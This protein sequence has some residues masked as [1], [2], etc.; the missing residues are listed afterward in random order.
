MNKKLLWAIALFGISLFPVPSHAQCSDKQDQFCRNLQYILYAAQTDFRTFDE[1]QQ[2]N[3]FGLFSPSPKFP[4]FAREPR[5]ARP[6]SPD[7][8]L[9]AAKVP[10]RLSAWTS[11]VSMYMCEAR[12]PVVDADEWYDK[13]LAELQQLQYLWKFNVQ[14]PG[15][16]HYVDAGPADCDAPITDGLYITDGP[17]AGQCPLH[18][19][20]VRQPDGTDSIHFW[21][22]SYTS[23]F[24]A[25][26]QGA[27]PVGLNA[28]KAPVGSGSATTQVA[29]VSSGAATA[30]P[31]SSTSPAPAE[32]PAI[33]SGSAVASSG[34]SAPATDDH[35]P[36]AHPGCDEFCQSLKKVLEDRWTAFKELNGVAAGSGTADAS[37]SANVSAAS[38]VKLSG[39]SSCSIR[40]LPP[41]SERSAAN[42]PISRVRLTPATLKGKP[43]PTPTQYVC[44]WPE[45]SPAAAESQFETL[46]SVLE[47]LIPST[48]SARQQ[49]QSDELSGAQVTVWSAH[50]ASNAPAVRLYLSG[51]SVG[52]HV[53]S[54]SE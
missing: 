32:P 7:I 16:D 50:D 49:S 28:V 44:Y 5:A 35:A 48:W 24:L 38:T 29:Q 31:V 17:Y 22:N 12:V 14:S 30:Q 6:D 53:S 13:T 9:D 1:H 47:F 26:H 34:Q 51:Q 20:T 54:A 52:L 36:A 46:V 21:V 11:G 39:A 10:C 2:F 25:R 27:A 37:A 43:S 33:P 41:D 15:T 42:T 3:D 45:S 23:P 8:S 19:Q 40:S 4:R 18:L